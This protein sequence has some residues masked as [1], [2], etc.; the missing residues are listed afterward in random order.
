MSSTL[1]GELVGAS[2][3]LGDAASKGLEQPRQH[4]CPQRQPEEHDRLIYAN[5][6]P[7]LT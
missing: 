2:K 3:E 6:L 7:D 1:A 5:S 4:G